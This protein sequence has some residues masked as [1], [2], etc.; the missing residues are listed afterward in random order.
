M[1]AVLRE[2]SLRAAIASTAATRSLPT[3]DIWRFKSG[4]LMGAGRGQP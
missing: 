4:Q 1:A 2:Y 3:R